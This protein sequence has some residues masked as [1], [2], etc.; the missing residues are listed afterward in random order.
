MVNWYWTKEAFYKK[1]TININT[2]TIVAARALDRIVGKVEVNI[3]DAAANQSIYVRVDKECGAYFF[4]TGLTD[5]VYTDPD[6]PY[7]DNP[8]II[9]PFVRVSGTKFER[10]SLN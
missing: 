4:N 1:F 6:I 10:F 2:D 9:R 3:L 5:S 8:Q 7:I